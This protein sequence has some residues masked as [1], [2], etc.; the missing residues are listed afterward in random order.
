MIER[1]NKDETLQRKNPRLRDFV[2]KFI[3]VPSGVLAV[4]RINQF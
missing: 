3:E 1:V 2:F 4:N